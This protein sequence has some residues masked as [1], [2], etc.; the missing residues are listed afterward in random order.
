VLED[1]SKEELGWQ[2][3]ML[4]PEFVYFRHRPMSGRKEELGEFVFKDGEA[5]SAEIFSLSLHS[6][7]PDLVCVSMLPCMNP[8]GFFSFFSNCLCPKIPSWSNCA[9]FLSWSVHKGMCSSLCHSD[10]FLANP[11]VSRFFSRDTG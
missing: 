8:L 11:G 9:L 2:L 5:L 10:F 6:K 1:P 7:T 3:E 4:Q